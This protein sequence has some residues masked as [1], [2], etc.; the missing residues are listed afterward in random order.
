[1]PVAVRSARRFVWPLIVRVAV[2]TVISTSSGLKPGSDASTRISSAVARH[3]ERQPGASVEDAGQLRGRTKLSSKSRSIAERSDKSSPNGDGRR[4]IVMVVN[5]HAGAV[6]GA[7]RVAWV[8]CRIP[9]TTGV[10]K[11]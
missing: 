3:V 11:P 4:T 10:L 2:S 7:F 5:L 6:S 1:M 8:G 9:D